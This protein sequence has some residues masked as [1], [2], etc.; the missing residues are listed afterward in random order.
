[1]NING[2]KKFFTKGKSLAALVGVASFM[3]YSAANACTGVLNNSNNAVGTYNG[4][5][6]SF[7]KQENA[8][9]VSV[10]CG[11]AGYY[12]VDWSNVFNWVGGM[13]WKPGS[14]RIVNYRGTFNSGRNRSSNNSYLALYGWT[15]P[16]VE[17][18]YYVVESYGSYNPASCGG[19]GGVAGGGGS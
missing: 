12:K 13:G 5:Y 9:R 7:W 15:R 14:A 8:N 6:Y 18:E 17:V 3:S 4:F 19:S 10:T 2:V 1:M 11:D 16:P